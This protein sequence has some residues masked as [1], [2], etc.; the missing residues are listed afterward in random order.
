[1][2]VSMI[3][4]GVKVTMDVF[5]VPDKSDPIARSF[6]FGHRV[7][8]ENN[9]PFPIRLL[10]MRLEINPVTGLPIEHTLPTV[11]G[12][13]PALE[14]GEHFE[15]M[16]GITMERELGWLTTHFDVIDAVTGEELEVPE[17]TLYLEAETILN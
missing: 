11:G 16:E 6:A 12:K 2:L 8:I 9:N 5:Y 17:L 7:H 1:M 4:S 10:S 13:Q 14:E 3:T 15:F